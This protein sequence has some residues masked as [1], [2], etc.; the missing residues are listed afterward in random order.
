[1]EVIKMIELRNE[2]LAAPIDEWHYVPFAENHHKWLLEWH[3]IDDDDGEFCFTFES[4]RRRRYSF[5]AE[6]GEHGGGRVI[7]AEVYDANIRQTASWWEDCGDKA[8]RLHALLK[9]TPDHILYRLYMLL[10]A[11]G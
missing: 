5:F 6:R 3:K 11:I 9:L 2:L 8:D 1:M 4:P 7:G 10:D